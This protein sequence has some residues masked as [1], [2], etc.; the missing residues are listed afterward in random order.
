MLIDS[1]NNDFSL[2]TVIKKNGS[3]GRLEPAL[4]A[5]KEG[6][7]LSNCQ[8]LGIRVENLE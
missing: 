2:L 8:N 7:Q 4:K 6:W 3:F 5:P 1:T